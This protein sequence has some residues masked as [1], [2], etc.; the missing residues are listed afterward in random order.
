M[1][2]ARG[3]RADGGG[4]AGP[5]PEADAVSA[6]TGERSGEHAAHDVEFLRRVRE[7]L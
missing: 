1:G 7:G 2:R 6:A 5:Y 4:A 3:V